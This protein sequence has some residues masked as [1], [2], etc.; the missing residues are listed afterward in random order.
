MSPVAARAQLARARQMPHVSGRRVDVH[1]MAIGDG[2]GARDRG[3]RESQ[4]ALNHPFIDGS[5]RVAAFARSSLP[6]PTVTSPGDAG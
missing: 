4:L 1:G 3:A 5:E 6:N 2:A